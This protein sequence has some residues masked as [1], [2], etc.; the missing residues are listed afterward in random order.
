M[1]AP[2]AIESSYLFPTGIAIYETLDKL[3]KKRNSI[4]HF[5]PDVF[6]GDKKILKGSDYDRVSFFEDMKWLRRYFSL[7]YDLNT[8]IL[9]AFPNHNPEFFYSTIEGQLMMPPNTI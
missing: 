4:V 7:P 8:F 5:K 1:I 2:K 6:I 3:V 9:K